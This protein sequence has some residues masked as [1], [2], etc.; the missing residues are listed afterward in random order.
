[1]VVAPDLR[2]GR[3]PGEAERNYRK[4]MPIILS[5]RHILKKQVYKAPPLRVACRPGGPAPLPSGSKKS[6][7]EFYVTGRVDSS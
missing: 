3:P 5:K 2:D 7:H 6:Y 1:M 4:A